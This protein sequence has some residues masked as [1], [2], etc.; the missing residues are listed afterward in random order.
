MNDFLFYGALT[1]IQALHVQ[2]WPWDPCVYNQN[3]VLASKK[4]HVL[5]V[6]L[7]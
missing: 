3:A 5:R 1:N 7:L 6:W 2:G 4:L